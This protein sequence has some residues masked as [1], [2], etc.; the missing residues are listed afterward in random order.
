MDR[1]QARFILQSF[2]PDGADVKDQD[3]A[4]ALAMAMENRELGEWLA[5]ERAIDAAFAQ[6]LASVTL[7]ETLRQDILGC[8]AGECG[9]FPQ[10][11]DAHDAAVSDAL[12][13][14]TPPHALRNRIL[15]A[16]DRT[17]VDRT[18]RCRCALVGRATPPL[19]Q[20][21]AVPTAA[22]AGIALGLCLTHQ[23]D[24]AVLA[25]TSPLPVEVVQ[26]GFIRSLESPRF[27]RDEPREDPQALLANLQARKLPCPCGLPRGLTDVQGTGCRELIIDG[28]RGSLVC[29][30]VRSQ[31][32]V[33]LVIFRRVDVCGELPPRDHP[34]FAQDGHWASAR[35]EHDQNVFILIGDTEVGKLAALF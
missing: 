8:L 1:E 20:R 16:M 32:V 12:A 35:W 5:Q 15:V 21:L 2:R 23:N 34:A 13:A 33:H 10:A 30:D 18:T 22:A 14:L 24:A 3:F 28:K 7:P 11:E 17:V 29:Y 9:A 26:A 4:A 6:A 25:T 27:R 19:W 31:G